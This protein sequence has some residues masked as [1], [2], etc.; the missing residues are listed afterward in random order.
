LDVMMPEMDGPTTLTCL[1]AIPSVA[2]T[3]VVFMTAKAQRNEIAYF[4]TLGALD[5][6]PKPFDPMTL[7]ATLRAI[8]AHASVVSQEQPTPAAETSR[9]NDSTALTPQQRFAARMV[10]LTAQFQRELPLRLT[11]LRAQWLELQ[12]SWSLDA[13]NSLHGSV[14]NLAGAGSTF[15]YDEVTARARALDRHLKILLAEQKQP[16]TMLRVEISA[17]FAELEAELRRIVLQLQS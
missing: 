2:D 13:V 16:D 14:H 11:T 8:W 12:G 4:K 5:V 1:R 10:E 15:G 7:A 3:P 9:E 6:I 17:L